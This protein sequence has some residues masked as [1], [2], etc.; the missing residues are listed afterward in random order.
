MTENEFA[1]FIKKGLGTPDVSPALAT[2]IA[3]EVDR[4]N[5]PNDDSPRAKRQKLL[6]RR[7]RTLSLRVGVAA[8]VLA[9]IGAVNLGIAY[10]Y[11]RY[12]VALAN[13]P[14]VGGVSQTLLSSAGLVTADIAAVSDVSTS[15][16]HTLRLMGAYA[17]GLQTVFLVQIDN[18]SLATAGWGNKKSTFLVARD[19]DLID[20]F[21]HTYEVS[22]SG[23]FPQGVEVFQPL[24][25]PAAENG[26]RLTLNIRVLGNVG[27][28]EA[29]S[30]NW[31]L[32][33][34]VFE[35]PSH[36]IPVPR[37]ITLA[38]NTF[39]FESIRSSTILYVKW[40]VTGPSVVQAWEAGD[41]G[42]FSSLSPFIPTLVGCPTAPYGSGAGYEFD[43]STKTMS[44]EL[45]YTLTGHGTCVIRFGS[46]Q[47]GFGHRTI[48]IPKP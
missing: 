43:P 42:S 14:I 46:G 8:L 13:A 12:G 36:V 35:H 7:F 37:P 26:A 34:T 17:D 5:R 41:K 47:L 19:M 33:A 38:G 22:K 24:V 44:S 29:I 4:R 10:Y 40:N 1:R 2:R 32:R 3:R 45:R 25:S 48:V 15:N 16:G 30:G 23:Q 18:Q 27:T 21:G 9:M 20:Q 28:G 31:A 6:P 11:P 39:T